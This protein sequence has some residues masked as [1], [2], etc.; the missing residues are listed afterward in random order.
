MSTRV[1]I[2]ITQEHFK[3]EVCRKTDGG[4]CQVIDTLEKV[5]DTH[6]SVVYSGN[7]LLVREVPA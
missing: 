5:G 7:E 6:E 4:E 3:V 2:E 1:K